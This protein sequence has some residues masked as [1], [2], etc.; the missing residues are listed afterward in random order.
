MV[1]TFVLPDANL[2]GGTR[3]IAIYAERL[4]RKGH[5][6][7]VVSTPRRTPP[8]G[9]RVLSLLRG[10]GWPV[11]RPLG[12]SHLD[13][14]NIEHR[15][16]DRWRPI[17]DDDVPDGDVVIATWWET[18]EWVYG[19]SQTKGA[20]V[21]FVQDYGAHDGQP[22][23]KLAPTWRLPMHKIVIS[24]YIQQ[25]V[26]DHADDRDV[27]FVPN[28]VDTGQFYAPPRGKQPRPTVGTAYSERPQKG[29][30]TALEAVRLAQ[31]QVPEL[32]FI[33]FGSEPTR[34][35]PDRT[36][37]FASAPEH[38][39]RTIYGRCDA[40]LFASRREGFGL[41]ILEAMACRTPVIATPAGA[42]P[43]LLTEG[44][45]IL[46]KPDDPADMAAAI[47]RIAQM[48]EAEWR[49]MSDA[50]CTTATRYTWEDA[51]ARFES[52]LHRALEKDASARAATV[53]P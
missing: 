12:P 51:A 27:S 33:A 39:L 26:A 50:A 9:R 53:L 24:R 21:Y 6:V 20:K 11:D 18:A 49:S 1:I 13:G 25:L 32:E 47:V 52:A 5:T 42:A 14:L 15:V 2:L 31:R 35:L 16:I 41:P 28:S 48:P 34:T 4:R 10:R 37:Y 8:W 30:E 46:V 7:R 45:G 43:E 23:L 40:W 38:E 36:E 3:V 29:V 19:L 17:T 44:G 22:L